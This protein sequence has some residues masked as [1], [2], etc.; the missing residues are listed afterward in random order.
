MN[1]HID[2]KLAL[3]SGSTAG[4]GLAIATS[5][6][7]EGTRVIV[8]GR[9]A[10]RVEKALAPIRGQPPDA[11]LESFAGDLSTEQAASDLVG[12]FPGIEILINNLGIFETKPFAE[13]PD[14]DW[15]R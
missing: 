9:T 2:N 11:Q 15:R 3:V 6:A 5:L 14:E 13:I 12:R 7:A 1:L 8:N 10:E 4:I